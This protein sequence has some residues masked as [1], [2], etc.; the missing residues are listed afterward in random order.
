MACEETLNALIVAII[1]QGGPSYKFAVID[2]I[3]NHDGGIPGGNI[4]PAFLYNPKRVSLA[5]PLSKE[6][7]TAN[8]AQQVIK[9]PQGVGFKY[10]PARVDPQNAAWTEARKS[11]SMAFEF[12][13][14]TIFIVNNHLKSKMESTSMFATLQP[15]KNAGVNK[16]IEQVQ[17]LNAF[18]KEIVTM[19]PN[20]K[21][22]LIGDFNEF[23]MA[24]P[25][26]QF[27][28]AGVLTELMEHLLPKEEVYTYNWDGNSQG[29]VIDL[30]LN[31]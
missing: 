9:T 29:N 2:P 27:N 1:H 23:T 17:V 7:A 14:H 19:D 12:N 28:E 24:P 15:P 16:R 6:K 8:Q 3:N 25:L 10:N 26:M 4:R 5:K 22:M 20:A 21:V 31:N 13:G 11:L 30:F 18:V